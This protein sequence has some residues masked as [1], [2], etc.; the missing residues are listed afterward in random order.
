MY[1]SYYLVF[2]EKWNSILESCIIFGNVTIVKDFLP[3]YLPELEDQQTSVEY[4]ETMMRYISSAAKSLTKND[5]ERILDEVETNYPEGSEV[6][7]TL[8][9]MWREEGM[10][11][12]MEKGFQEGLVDMAT[13]GLIEKFKKVPMDV[14]EGIQKL[15][16]P[17]L[18]V[19]VMK[20][21]SFESLDEVREY[22]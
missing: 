7:M 15:D 20:M 12:G 5:V 21:M 8:A 16:S 1:D 10:E 2:L 13:Q 9:D 18:K 19:I 17:V 6:A 3:N 14:R 11:K 4:F 22:L